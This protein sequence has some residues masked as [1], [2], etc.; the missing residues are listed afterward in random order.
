MKLYDLSV[1]WK[2]VYRNTKGY[3]I[4]YNSKNIYI[5]L[6]DNVAVVKII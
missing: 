6:S 4:K 2:C 3:Y 1:E 5:Y